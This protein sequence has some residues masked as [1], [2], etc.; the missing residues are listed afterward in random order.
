MKLKSYYY[1]IVGVFCLFFENQ[2]L[3][4][5]KIQIPREV[6]NILTDEDYQRQYAQIMGQGA[7]IREG[8][9]IAT[10]K[11]YGFNPNDVDE[12]ELNACME[13]DLNEWT[14]QGH[15]PSLEPAYYALYRIQQFHGN[16]SEWAQKSKNDFFYA[17]GGKCC[18]DNGVSFEDFES[19]TGETNI[20][21]AL[22]QAGLI[23][24]QTE[25]EFAMFC[26]KHLLLLSNGQVPAFLFGS[27]PDP[28]SN[29]IR[30]L[31]AGLRMLSNLLWDQGYKTEAESLKRE[32]HI[33][34]EAIYNVVQYR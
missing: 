25:P 14:Q 26:F 20:Y 34:S 12:G 16:T 9:K 6:M 31:Q 2:T 24:M 27:N 15:K 3:F 18:C 22:Y 1:I 28:E 5:A 17:D 4:G 33:L 8:Y 10:C 29:A 23:F 11:T 32:S 19:P 21:W 30:R 13:E 7:E